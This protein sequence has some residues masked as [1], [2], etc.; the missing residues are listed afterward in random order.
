MASMQ[1]FG[2]ATPSEPI[3]TQSSQPSFFARIFGRWGQRYPV[4]PLF[5]LRRSRDVKEI[6]DT[7]T[8]RST[9]RD[10]SPGVSARAWAADKPGSS[11]I[12]ESDGVCV[13]REIHLECQELDGA[14]KERKSDNDWA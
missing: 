7:D 6:I 9:A 1:R 2:S 8:Q 3:V 4:L 12:R 11:Y 10:Q 14:A 13:F 5:S